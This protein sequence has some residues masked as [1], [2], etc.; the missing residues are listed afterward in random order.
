MIFTTK[1]AKISESPLFLPFPN[2]FEK[3]NQPERTS[4]KAS[5][6]KKAAALFCLIQFEQE[7]TQI[8]FDRLFFDLNNGFH[9]DRDI[10]GQ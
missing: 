2:G 4:Q 5:N 8:I 7:T 9:F 1:T 6:Q 10:P 3:T